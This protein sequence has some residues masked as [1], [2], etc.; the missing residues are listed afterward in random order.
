MRR[1]STQLK[2]GVNE[3]APVFSELKL[4]V[5]AMILLFSTEVELGVNESAPFRPAEVG[6]MNGRLFSV[7]LKEA[8]GPAQ[9]GGD[10]RAHKAGLVSNNNKKE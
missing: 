4:S 9:L 2:L 10:E 7:C 6:L 3:M 1:S 8:C 5:N